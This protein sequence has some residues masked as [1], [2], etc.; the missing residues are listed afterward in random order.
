MVGVSVQNRPQTAHAALALRPRT[1]QRAGSRRNGL[2][3]GRWPK[4]PRASALAAA[5]RRLPLQSRC[6]VKPKQLRKSSSGP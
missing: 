3:A 5:A 1:K 6:T 2:A 4:Q